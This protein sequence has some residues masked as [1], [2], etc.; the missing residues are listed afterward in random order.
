MSNLFAKALI[1]EEN[2]TIT[3]NGDLA[4]K[5]TNSKVLDFFS[6]AGSI[7][8][9]PEQEKINLF[10]VAFLE[11]NLLSLKALF[12]LRDI[13]GGS[14]ERDTFRIIL[15]EQAR[16]FPDS[17]RKNLHLISEYGRWDDLFVL[18]GTN[19][20]KD[21]LNLLKTQLL[22]DMNA[23]EGESISLLA[24]WMKSSNTSSKKSVE[25]ANKFIKHFE[26][27]P[28]QYRKMLV[29]L[30]SKLNVI[31]TQ[32]SSNQWKVIKYERVP[33]RAS[34][35]YRKAFK[36]HD[37]TRYASYLEK[38]ASGDA[39]IKTSGL[40][41]YELVYK[42]KH[43][44]VE[45]KT[46]DV[47]WNALPLLIPEGINAIAI[48][49]TSG[50]MDQ[51]I[52]K[53][54]KATALDVS[55]AMAIY[56]AEKNNGPFKDMFI[57]FSSRPTLHKITGKTIREK[58]SNIRMIIENTNLM[59]ALDLLLKV[60]VE[61]K[62][63]KEDMLDVIFIFSD[64]QFDCCGAYNKSTYQIA[65]EKFNNAGYELP[66]VVFWNLAG[67]LDNNPA[68]K[69]EMGVTLVSGFSSNLFK[70]FLLGADAYSNMLETLNSDRYSKISL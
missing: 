25:L 37:D 20:E 65:K 70:T 58:V 34:M 11:D 44:S 24:K 9:V 54:T 51:N 61:N 50:S 57:T 18:I 17:I 10:N 29:K 62:I 2:K 64:M 32:M 48:S 16:R 43:E 38:V 55:V 19:L 49:D 7:R 28:R 40:F 14:G 23:G 39:K 15:K 22:K 45:S 12:H 60:A 5:S 33:S 66:K 41:P 36:K 31:E 56:L 63:P 53:G 67:K 26:V 8:T 47:M 68:T 30:R 4:F 1:S 42:A 27:T 3:T 13:R 21:V 46:L 35:I 52:S 69:D 59:A 6:K